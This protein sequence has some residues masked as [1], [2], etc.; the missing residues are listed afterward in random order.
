MYEFIN[1]FAYSDDESIV[2]SM[3]PILGGPDWPSR[4]DTK[5][6][7]GLAVE[8]LFRETLKS[9]GNFTF[10]I[11][12]KIDKA[13][14]ERPHFFII[15]GTKSP[16]GLKAFR[17][18]E[19][20]ALREHVRSRADAREKRREERSDTADLFRGYHAD[21]Q[22][23]TIDTIISEQ[24]K[25]ASDHL[26]AILE[27]GALPFSK[28]VIRLLEA[29]MLRETNIKDICTE[30]AATGKIERTWGGGNRKPADDSLIRLKAL[31]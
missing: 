24:K 5:L 4:L 29:Y 22:E 31:N 7:R 30:I 13:T 19:Y 20:V 23:A 21:V 11:S 1:R 17:D 27:Q 14:A 3:A 16:D 10:V 12:T 25:L 2:A 28:V 9:V 8:R 18:T 6:P 15:Y 26:L